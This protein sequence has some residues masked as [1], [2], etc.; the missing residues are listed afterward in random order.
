[1]LGHFLLDQE[2]AAA[3]ALFAGYWEG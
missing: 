1:M 3:H 2:A